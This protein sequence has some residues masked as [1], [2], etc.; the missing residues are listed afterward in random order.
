MTKEERDSILNGLN[1]AIDYI[2]S[3]RE[4]GDDSPLTKEEQDKMFKILNGLNTEKK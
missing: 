4:D 2:K 1:N 3:I